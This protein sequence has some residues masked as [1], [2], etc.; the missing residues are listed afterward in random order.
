MA[1]TSGVRR[2]GVL[3]KS[4]LRTAPRTS[5]YLREGH[6]LPSLEKRLERN[7]NLGLVRQLLLDGQSVGQFS[8]DTTAESRIERTTRA[9][10]WRWGGCVVDADAGPAGRP[11]D[12]AD[13]L[14]SRE[15]QN[16]L[17]SRLR[18]EGSKTEALFATSSSMV[19]P[20]T[21]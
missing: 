11:T 21:I 9:W 6:H 7:E 20:P 5:C 12:E 3:Y 8:P 14:F 1:S 16:D 10:F 19:R 17:T 4:A 2:V 13:R 15:R 18:V